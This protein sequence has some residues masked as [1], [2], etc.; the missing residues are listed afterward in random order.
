MAEIRYTQYRGLTCSEPWRVFLT[1]AERDGVDFDA[2]SLR[3]SMSEQGVLFRQN[4]YPDGSGPRPGRPLTA[5][6]SSTAPHIKVGRWDHAGDFNGAGNLIAY[7]ARKGIRLV[8]TVAS[9]IWHLEFVGVS[10][11]RILE[12]FGLVDPFDFLADR[13]ARLIR[14]AQ[15]K[16]DRARRRGRWLKSE[17]AR[18]KSINVYLRTKVRALKT[19]ALRRRLTERERKRLNYL[20]D[21]I[22]GRELA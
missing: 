13:E 3:R 15:L 11:E 22:A 21:A 9:E 17:I 10:A 14:E 7:A 16:R 19:K 2:N 8:R 5:R 4:M 1:A 6:P 20:R 18:V 12:V